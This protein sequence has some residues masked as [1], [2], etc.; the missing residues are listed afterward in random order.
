MQPSQPGDPLSI[1]H[2]PGLRVEHDHGNK[3]GPPTRHF[4]KQS[5]VTVAPMAVVEVSNGH[6]IKTR[7]GLTPDHDALAGGKTHSDFLIAH[8]LELSYK[9]RRLSCTLGFSGSDAGEYRI[10]KRPW[11]T[12]TDT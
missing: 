11:P 3:A 10:P 6:C 4:D 9:N 7:R 12:S 5:C 1:E 2:S 8:R